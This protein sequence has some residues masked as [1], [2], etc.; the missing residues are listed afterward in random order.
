MVFIK[1]GGYSISSSLIIPYDRIMICGEGVA[2]VLKGES[3]VGTIIKTSDDR[4]TYHTV[5]RDLAI[6]GMNSADYG[7]EIHANKALIEN[8]WIRQ[9]NLACIHAGHNPDLGVVYDL[10]IRNVRLDESAGYGLLNEKYASDT[11][12]KDSYIQGCAKGSV[13]VLGNGFYCIN[14]HFYRY[15]SLQEHF[16]DYHF[17]I[18]GIDQGISGIFI[19]GNYMEKPNKHVIYVNV[20]YDVSLLEIINNYLV[21]YSEA[22]VGTYDII[23]LEATSGWLRRVRIENNFL[24]GAN[25]ANKAVELIRPSTV[26]QERPIIRGNRYNKITD[27]GYVTRQSGIATIPAGSTSVTVNHNLPWIPTRIFVQPYDVNV[28]SWWVSNR[29]STSF[30]INIPSAL[31]VD[32]HFFWLIDDYEPVTP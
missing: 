16:P 19:Y 32:A 30:D 12:L 31:D 29:T 20:S 11:W 23:H 24:D 27:V 1:R 25:V 13:K 26:T 2:T 8:V 14:N 18:T 9:C 6:N 17:E 5:I 15:G 28:T 21:M 7:I 22:P 4:K 10:H 3:G